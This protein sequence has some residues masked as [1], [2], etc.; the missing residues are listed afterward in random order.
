MLLL[1]SSPVVAWFYLFL[2]TGVCVSSV[3]TLK[4][5]NILTFLLQ[6]GFVFPV[7]PVLLCT[8]LVPR[9]GDDNFNEFLFNKRLMKIT[10][11]IVMLFS[12]A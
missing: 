4:W 9:K 12:F 11:W 10:K 1:L 6:K 7:K 8:I 3:K 2:L 5:Y